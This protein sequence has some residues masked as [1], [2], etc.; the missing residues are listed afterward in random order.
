MSKASEESKETEQGSSMLHWSES[1]MMG[2]PRIDQQH[3]GLVNLINLLSQLQGR[4]R[5]G[6]VELVWRQLEQ[7]LQE[8]LRYEEQLLERY[9]FDGLEAHRLEHQQLRETVEQL[10]S[11]EDGAALLKY[12][13]GWFSDHVR[14]K[15]MEYA[16]Y[17]R[18]HM[19]AD[20][21]LS[22]DLRRPCG[23][24]RLL[25]VDDE[26]EVL[27]HYRTSLTPRS[28]QRRKQIEQELFAAVQE[29]EPEPL[30][31]EETAACERFEFSTATQ[32]EEA[33]ELAREALYADTPF[34][35]AFID[36]RMP[37][38]IDGLETARR[39]RSLDERI[40]IV[41]VTAYSDYD[42]NALDEVLMHDM[43]Y[44]R[45]PFSSVEIQQL[46]R[47]L[48]RSWCHQR[49]LESSVSRV[50]LEAV[51][52]AASN[53]DRFFTAVS[54]ELRTPLTAMIGNSEIL[55]EMVVDEEQQELLRSIEVS[56][57]GL[58]SLINDILDLSKIEAGKFSI[59]HTPYDLGALLEEISY[60]FSARAADAGIEFLIARQP[61]LTHQL[62]GDGRRIG[63]ILINLI[64][65]AIKF[66]PQG[67]VT[68]EV[69]IES[70]NA[71]EGAGE[72][73]QMAVI[74][75]GVGIAPQAL[76]RLFQPFEQA[77][78][79][80]SGRFGGSGLG[81]HISRVLVELMGGMIEVQS[82]EGAGSRFTL[83]I[84]YALS[85][86][87]AGVEGRQRRRA[88]SRSGSFSGY[89]LVA[90]DTP[91]L[92]ILEQRLLTMM[93][94]RVTLA[95]DGAEAVEKGL[96]DHYDLILMDMQMPKMDGL[97]ATRLLRQ[98]GVSVP[99]VA[100][101]ANAMEQHRQ[102]AE[103]AGCDGFLSK[104]I[105]TNGLRQLL[106][107]Y[108]Q[109]CSE[110]PPQPQRVEMDGDLQQLFVERTA[111]S[112]GALQQALEKEA[113]EEVARLAHMVKGT[114]GSFG[115]PELTALGS[116]VC[117][118]LREEQK[119]PSEQLH[120]EVRQLI[121]AMQQV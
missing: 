20:Q 81:L 30:S 93:G 54:H 91:E 56:G 42:V 46:A 17:L 113:W 106:Q 70:E 22:A 112:C 60:I 28:S 8:H 33:V 6:A 26:L 1:L 77:D 118:S 27:E 121:E 83:R 65:N 115:Y 39:L 97:E 72:W 105:D 98:A 87:P 35:V 90:E 14:G 55:A 45:K 50:E 61:P 71:G 79:S 38:G 92:Q 49:Q 89:V 62:L 86:T 3:Q 88:L 111:E 69:S 73:L 15:D 2:I 116:R 37:P 85:E 41:F 31:E 63:Q 95:R 25:L 23:E 43:F 10:R 100:L 108:L 99:I 94:V 4:R 64:G 102:Q 18:L 120:A 78:D 117:D 109:Q 5:R 11:T 67:K 13:R 53:K 101:T 110:Q 47:N 40:Q 34:S 103:E 107:Q 29:E 12:L 59:D 68:L 7:Y 119:P 57:H 19:Q 21:T 76:K 36:I 52:R 16:D 114:G 48:G 82:E 51:E 75:E 58:L 9:A 84:P 74:D 44:L 104:P 96:A 80:V 66:T 32:G 24:V